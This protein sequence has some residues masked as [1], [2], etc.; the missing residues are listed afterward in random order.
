MN[1]QLQIAVQT[2]ADQFHAESK[3]FR[4][5]MSVTFA[6]EH[7]VEACKLLRDKFGFRTLTDETAVDYWPNTRDNARFHLI[8]N[9]Y[10]LKENFRLRLRTPILSDDPLTQSVVEVYPNANWYEREIWD[11]FGIR[12]EGHPNLTR[13]LLPDDWVGHPLRKD[14]SLGGEE[15]QFSFSFDEI[16]LSKPKG[17]LP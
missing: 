16:D 4:G 7:I 5:Q 15:V 13:I 6:Q 3:I 8:Y 10:N 14:H 12:F 9:L 2:L 17:V 1:E 11:L